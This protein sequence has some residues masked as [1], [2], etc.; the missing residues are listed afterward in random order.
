MLCGFRDYRSIAPGLAGVLFG[1][2]FSGSALAEPIAASGF[3][4]L[5]GGLLAGARRGFLGVRIDPCS[6]VGFGREGGTVTLVAGGP[7]G[8]KGFGLCVFNVFGAA[9]GVDDV[10]GG[11]LGDLLNG[12]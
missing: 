5:T 4:V 7:G 11:L 1:I 3:I 2:G 8:L 10:L 12:T 9:E 6:G